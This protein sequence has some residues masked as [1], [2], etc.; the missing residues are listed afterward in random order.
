MWL[1]EPATLIVSLCLSLRFVIKKSSQCVV[2]LHFQSLKYAT[3]Y[4]IEI[5]PIILGTDLLRFFTSLSLS[6]QRSFET[7]NSTD[8][9]VDDPGSVKD[10]PG[11]RGSSSF[12]R[13]SILIVIL[14]FM[15]NQSFLSYQDDSWSISVVL[16]SSTGLARPE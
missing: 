16:R 3:D 11:S 9:E 7:N 13:H 14:S 1:L 10:E 6:L 2:E 12:L 4:G 5:H 8:R 15:K